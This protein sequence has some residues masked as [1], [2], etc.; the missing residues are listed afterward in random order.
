MRIVVVVVLFF[1]CSAFDSPAASWRTT[2][3][4][5]FGSVPRS[6]T[7]AGAHMATFRSMPQKCM[8]TYF[9]GTSRA[10]HAFG[11]AASVRTSRP[12]LSFREGPPRYVAF[13]YALKHFEA[14]AL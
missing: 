14:L 1:S 10:S 13:L 9:C 4:E 2:L 5:R 11:P 6:K 12:E 3:V 7:H 8:T